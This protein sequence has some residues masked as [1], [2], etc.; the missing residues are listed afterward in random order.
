[1]GLGRGTMADERVQLGNI[2]VG[3][4]EVQTN[5]VYIIS[6]RGEASVPC[7]PL[8]TETTRLDQGVELV[9]GNGFHRQ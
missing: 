9:G 7:L 5:P 8:P 4:V 2:P 6:K 1:M 3:T